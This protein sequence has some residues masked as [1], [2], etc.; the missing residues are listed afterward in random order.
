MLQNKMVYDVPTP[1][2]SLGLE[3]VTHVDYMHRLADEWNRFRTSCGRLEGELF[4][5]L[6]P[7]VFHTSLEGWRQLGGA[8]PYKTFVDTWHMEWRYLFNLGIHWQTSNHSLPYP[9]RL[10]A[11][12]AKFAYNYANCKYLLS[13]EGITRYFGPPQH[14]ECGAI[15]DPV[16]M[17][18][19]RTAL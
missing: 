18:G 12:Q 7:R 15:M 10:L 14:T 16:Y 1:I 11:C 9:T 17:E 2:C 19:T 13:E 3:D 4:D 6:G 8:H 5:I